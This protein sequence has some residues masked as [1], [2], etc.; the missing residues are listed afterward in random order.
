MKHLL[1]AKG[2]W[3]LVEG[4]EVLGEDNAQVQADFQQ[5]S[6]STVALAIS[7]S[8]LHLVTSCD[9]PKATWDALRNHFERDTLANKLFLRKQ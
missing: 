7:S 4:T 5:K 2:F 1:I 3:G 9:S 6:F 8:E